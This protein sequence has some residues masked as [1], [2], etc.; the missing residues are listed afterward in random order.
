MTERLGSS[1]ESETTSTFAYSP[2][3]LLGQLSISELNN[4]SQTITGPW[5]DTVTG[6]RDH[7]IHYFLNK[8]WQMPQTPPEAPYMPGSQKSADY[9]TDIRNYSTTHPF[10]PQEQFRF[11]RQGE[12]LYSIGK[13]FV[14]T[15]SPYE[16]ST[17]GGVISVTDFVVSNLQAIF[18]T[19]YRIAAHAYE[20]QLNDIIRSYLQPGNTSLQY[21]IDRKRVTPE[22]AAQVETALGNLRY[23]SPLPDFMQMPREQQQEIG[24]HVLQEIRGILGAIAQPSLIRQARQNTS[25][26]YVSLAEL[27]QALDNPANNPQDVYRTFLETPQRFRSLMLQP[28]TYTEE[29][30]RWGS[31]AHSSLPAPPVIHGPEVDLLPTS[32][33]ELKI[34][35]LLNDPEINTNVLDLRPGDTI[36]L[37]IPD[38]IVSLGSFERII[39]KHTQLIGRTL[40]EGIINPHPKGVS[41]PD[42]NALDIARLLRAGKRGQMFN[43]RIMNLRLTRLLVTR[44]QLDAAFPKSPAHRTTHVETAARLAFSVDFKSGGR[45]PIPHMQEIIIA[46]RQSSDRD[47]I[48]KA[49]LKK[50]GMGP[51]AL[52]TIFW[53]AAAISRVVQAY[54]LDSAVSSAPGTSRR[55]RGGH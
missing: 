4:L 7:R 22:S 28:P 35:Q 54:Y 10:Q 47:R 9:L 40:A 41:L 44:E 3:W 33:N 27:Q 1:S 52:E 43:G 15:L 51:E 17:S 6:Q 30:R 16:I 20:Q 19:P 8:V 2:L 53:E 21:T 25:L 11:H 48:Q 49:K 23:Y 36:P 37:T 39:D 26:A 29:R 31:R 38:T 32:P 42:W 55:S 45:E 5:A 12:Y 34:R 50:Q 46:A 13:R 18:L 24:Q 14:D